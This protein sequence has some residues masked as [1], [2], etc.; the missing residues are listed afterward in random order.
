MEE[1]DAGQRAKAAEERVKAARERA[2]N[3]EAMADAFEKVANRTEEHVRE[4]MK[5]LAL[6]VADK[7]NKT[8]AIALAFEKSANRTEA[9]M[10]QTVA[11]M[12]KVVDE[13]NKTEA[14]MEQR[15]GEMI[16]RHKNVTLI[17]HT[18]GEGKLF[19]RDAGATVDRNNI[20]GPETMVVVSHNSTMA[21]SNLLDADTEQFWTQNGSIYA[22]QGEEA[23]KEDG[24]VRAS[25]TAADLRGQVALSL[26][27]IML[28]VAT[29]AVPAMDY[30]TSDQLRGKSAVFGGM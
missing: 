27:G 26:P 19:K 17:G 21:V 29:A 30:N 6:A 7:A 23:E 1:Q 13:V 22:T 9:R 28:S 10:Q 24:D 12:A 25:A 5:Q 16:M 8:Q 11:E 18:G 3:V 14:A 15:A 20:D 4:T 2:Q